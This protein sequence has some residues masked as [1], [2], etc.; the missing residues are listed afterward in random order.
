MWSDRNAVAPRN[1]LRQSG[2]RPGRADGTLRTSVP[3]AWYLYRMHHLLLLVSGLCAPSVALAASDRSILDGISSTVVYGLVGIGMATIS[4]KVVDLI[5]PGNLSEELAHK[6][7]LALAFVAGS[8][9]LG[10]C[11]IIASVLFG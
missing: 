6:Q 8:M 11:I 3:T 10:I 1:Y 2:Y 4:Y 9:I 7:N 5:T